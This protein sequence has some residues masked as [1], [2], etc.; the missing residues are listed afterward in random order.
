MSTDRTVLQHQRLNELSTFG[1]KPIIKFNSNN[2]SSF[3]PGISSSVPIFS[4]ELTNLQP[5]SS[6]QNYI[7]TNNNICTNY[8]I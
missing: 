7:N 1:S 8:L 2:F 6:S 4:T 5:T 3:N